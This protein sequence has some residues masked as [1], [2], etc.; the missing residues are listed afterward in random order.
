MVKLEEVMIKEMEDFI[1]KLCCCWLR[2]ARKRLRL[3]LISSCSD[4]F[5][6]RR[7]SSL[8]FSR[9]FSVSVERFFLFFFWIRNCA[10]LLPALRSRRRWSC[11]FELSF[12][13]HSSTSSQIAHVGYSRW[14]FGQFSVC[15]D[16]D[17]V[18]ADC[19]SVDSW[20]DFDWC[21]C[22][23]INRNSVV[24][25]GFGWVLSV[26][27]MMM[28]MICENDWF[29][30]VKI[31]VD[32]DGGLWWVCDEFG[33]LWRLLWWLWRLLWWLWRLKVVVEGCWR[34]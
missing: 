19:A 12:V 23:G 1:P 30:D 33:R 18:D 24:N 32:D 6:C 26:K 31:V 29:G 28:M 4:L 17:G 8:S 27:V 20:M 5:G 34:S 16:S 21:R 2:F 22:S 7:P 11:E 3:R 25:G 14:S 10:L 15:S 13:L 9:S